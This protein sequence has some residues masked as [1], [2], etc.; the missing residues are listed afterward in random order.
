MIKFFRK[1]RQKLLDEGKT[2]KYFKYAI[3]E[4]VLV[5]I[6]ILIALQVSNWNQDRIK[7][8][9]EKDDLENLK[10]ELQ[11]NILEFR[12]QD[13]LFGSFERKTIE[14]LKILNNDLNIPNLIKMDTLISTRLKVFPLTRSTYDEMLN[15]GKF[16]NIQNKA[17]KAKINQFYAEADNYVVAFT[18]INNGI[19]AMLNHPNLYNFD[20]LLIKLKTEPKKLMAIDTTWL[21]NVNSP[22]YLTLY[23][24]A[25]YIQE[26]SNTTRRELIARQI[27][28]CNELITFI[29]AELAKRN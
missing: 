18:E 27:I 7:I 26:Y 16:Y 17:L 14:G 11:N 5:V 19:L 29:D 10:E 3:G 2:G 4:I 1:I 15:T 12:K 28:P 9:Q 25:N 22:T 21:H 24:K 8:I 6:G 13:S 20:Y 23:K